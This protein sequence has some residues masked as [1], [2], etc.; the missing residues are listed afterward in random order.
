MFLVLLKSTILLQNF[1][2]IKVESLSFTMTSQMPC[3]ANSM[4]SIAMACVAELV[5]T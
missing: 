3:V 5:V 2:P 1:A 4:R